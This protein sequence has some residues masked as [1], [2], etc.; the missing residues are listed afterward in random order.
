MIW[1]LLSLLAAPLQCDYRDNLFLVKQGENTYQQRVQ[2]R[3]YNFALSCAENLGGIYDG[4]DLTVF[5][6]KTKRFDWKNVRNNFDFSQSGASNNLVALYDGESFHAYRAEEGRFYSA[7]ANPDFRYSR[8][9]AAD[10]VAALYDGAQMIV[11]SDRFTARKARERFQHSKLSAGG[12]IALL[13]DGDGFIVYDAKDGGFSERSAKNGYL[14]ARVLASPIGAMGY[15]GDQVIAY[16]PG[17]KNLIAENVE[18]DAFSQ[19]LYDPVKKEIK[20]QVNKTWYQLDSGRCRLIR[21]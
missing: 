11:F 7:P 5:D 3:F 14:F 15:D 16:C 17:T 10:G 1:T 12:S 2:A 18:K 13:Y 9:E 19:A 8:V 6:G 20:L 21:R 4:D